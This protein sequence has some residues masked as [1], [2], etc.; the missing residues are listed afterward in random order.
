MA[1][2]FSGT[3][4]RA[5]IA[6]SLRTRCEAAG[7]QLVIEEID[8]LVGGA[9]H[10]LLDKGAQD[11]F[12]QRIEEGDFDC[13]ILSPPCG[14]WSRANFANDR[15]P[16]PC[17]HRM[18]PWGLP[19]QQPK[20]ARRAELGNE[21]V[22]FSIRALQ[23]VRSRRRKSG[24]HRST[25]TARKT[26][27]LLEHPEDLGATHRGHP[28]STWQLEET[29]KA[30]G[31]PGEFTTV[32]GHQCQFGVDYAKPTRLL[33]DLPGSRSSVTPVGRSSTAEIAI[34]D[35]SLTAVTNTRR[36]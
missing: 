25:A 8:I 16:Q 33:S 18:H 32:A 34:S 15:G 17:R 6:E 2:F 28:A 27:A 24:K 31:D 14:T 4:R 30:L 12:L 9:A 35:R 3:K 5:S 20:Q 13:V 23:A 26:T 21:F 1:Y 11:E 29:R 22:H 10:N 19:N 7:V 36:R